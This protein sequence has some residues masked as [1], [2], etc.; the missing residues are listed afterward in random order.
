MVNLPRA[1]RNHD[2]CLALELLPSPMLVACRQLSFWRRL[3]SWQLNREIASC[4]RHWCTWP[5]CYYTLTYA[6][7]TLLRPVGPEPPCSE[8]TQF[9]KHVRLLTGKLCSH[10]KR[11]DRHK[12]DIFLSFVSLCVCA[13]CVWECVCIIIIVTFHSTMNMCLM[14]WNKMKWNEIIMNISSNLDESILRLWFIKMEVLSL[15]KIR[16]SRETA[17]ALKN[18]SLHGFCF[19]EGNPSIQVIIRIND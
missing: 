8:W 2:M 11:N 15:R 5:A 19:H 10:T 18:F 12:S 14:A 4:Q 7:Q 9:N 16:P 13:L 17:S 3:H 1:T 6:D